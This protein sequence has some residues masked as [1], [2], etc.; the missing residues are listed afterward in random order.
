GSGR[1]SCRSQ[2]MRRHEDEPWRVQECV[3]QC[4][5]RRGGGD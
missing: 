3:S 5:R 4:R 2:C 1:G